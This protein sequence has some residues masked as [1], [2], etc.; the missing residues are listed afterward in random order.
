MGRPKRDPHQTPLRDGD[1][2]YITL[3]SGARM[4]VRTWQPGEQQWKYTNLGRGFF[5]RRQI[6]WIVEIPV[7]RQGQAA[8]QS[9]AV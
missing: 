4:L 9:G 6:E 1:R 8:Q 5:S 2:E 7:I 3:R